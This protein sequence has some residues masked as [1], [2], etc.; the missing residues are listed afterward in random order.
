MPWPPETEP[1]N[2]LHE[3]L[4]AVEEIRGY[5]QT[6]AFLQHEIDRLRVVAGL[7]AQRQKLLAPPAASQTVSA[8][9]LTTT[10]KALEFYADPSNYEAPKSGKDRRSEVAKDGGHRARI[11]LEEIAPD[12]EGESE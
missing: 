7:R 1:E 9:H 10:A 2:K 4:F 5:D 8:T 6:I 11:T 12:D 3:A